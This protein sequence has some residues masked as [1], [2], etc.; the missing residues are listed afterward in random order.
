M[1]YFKDIKRKPKIIDIT[2]DYEKDNQKQQS[3]AAENGSVTP[4]E[5]AVPELKTILEQLEK[6]R[7]G[8]KKN[9]TA[10]NHSSKPT[11]NAYS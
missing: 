1:D 3:N 10:E 8:E 5:N 2:E 7:K 11:G 9:N 4:G 6:D